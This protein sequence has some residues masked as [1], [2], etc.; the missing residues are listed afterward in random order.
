MIK[1]REIINN[2]K[3]PLLENTNDN[4]Y[5]A[6][7]YS[8]KTGHGEYKTDQN[9][10]NVLKLAVKRKS[11]E[12]SSGNLDTEIEYIGVTG[13]GID[14]AII[15]VTKNYLTKVLHPGDF[16]TKKDYQIFLKAGLKSIKSEKPVTGQFED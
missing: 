15:Y 7:Y 3:K 13:N 16:K 4:W 5:I 1:L 12:E 11:D 2:I 9:F 6:E 14:F 8:N 10:D